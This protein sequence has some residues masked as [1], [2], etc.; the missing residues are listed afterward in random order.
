VRGR[1]L[2]LSADT[3]QTLNNIAGQ[4]RIRTK[5]SGRKTG[6]TRDDDLGTGGSES[7]G[8]ADGAV[9]G[10]SPCQNVTGPGTRKHIGSL[11]HNKAHGSAL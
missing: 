8:Q 1:L 4:D 9:G 2:G 11:V 6:G 5:F 3:P 7:R 10:N